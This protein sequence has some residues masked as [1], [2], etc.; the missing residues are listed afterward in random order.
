M[1]FGL[2][3]EPP[4]CGALFCVDSTV[5]LDLE[6]DTES[7]IGIDDSAEPLA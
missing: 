4:S 2:R 7:G 3:V 5:G 6:A 1:S